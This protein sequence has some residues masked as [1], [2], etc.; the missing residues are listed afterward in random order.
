[1]PVVEREKKSMAKP[2]ATTNDAAPVVRTENPLTRSIQFFKDVRAEMR[3]V[4][5]PSREEVQSTT[6]V[7]I[8]SVFLF[9]A[10]FYV[11]DS[12]VG[13]ALQAL[14]HALGGQ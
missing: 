11:V 12:V 13:R 8:L 10:F 3:K 5:T 9:S 2:A 1:M 7:V 4:V 6:L 14:L